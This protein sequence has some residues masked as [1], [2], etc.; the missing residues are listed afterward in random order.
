M[1]AALLAA[2]GPVGPP[3]GRRT[4]PVCTLGVASGECPPDVAFYHAAP[5]S[6]R[7]ELGVIAAPTQVVTYTVIYDDPGY[8]GRSDS[9]T[10]TGGSDGHSFMI[11]IPMP[12]ITAITVTAMGAMGERGSMCSAVPL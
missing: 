2:C 7:A 1:A 9:F 12:A 11:D 4:Q 10:V 6:L 3:T 5:P 8:A